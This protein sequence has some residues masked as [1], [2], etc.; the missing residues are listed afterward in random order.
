VSAADIAAA[1][2]QG[3]DALCDVLRRRAAPGVSHEDPPLEAALLDAARSVLEKA[4]SA[5][6]GSQRVGDRAR[7]LVGLA[8]IY[9]STTSIQTL[10]AAERALVE[11]LQAVPIEVVGVLALDAYRLLLDVLV[12][13]V[14]A[15]SAEQRETFIERALGFA[16]A[17]GYVA[18]RMADDLGRARALAH[19]AALL[20]ERFRGDRDDNLMNAVDTGE[21]ALA[22]LPAG[23][24]ELEL[25][26]PL[27]LLVMG[28]ASVKIAADREAWL[29][30]GIEYYTKGRASVD[31]TRHPGLAR[32]LEGNAAVYREQSEEERRQLPPKE[33]YARSSAR[34]RESAAA[35]DVE[36][37][38]ATASDTIAWAHALA[39]QPNQYV[40]HAHVTLGQLYLSLERWREAREQLDQGLVV[41]TSLFA[42]GS[43]GHGYVRSALALREQAVAK[44]GGSATSCRG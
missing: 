4:V 7:A 12:K 41:L 1:L 27:L 44:E 16:R 40:G 39:D 43:H 29:R 33:M 23:T 5:A 19:E 32:V 17:G 31:V 9:A 13:V 15:V 24:L 3:P 25:R 6:Q 36:A 37:A 10:Q 22:L 30:R 2:V 34:V 35:G 38:L 11:A 14:D 28:N 42:P 20:S 18:T 8:H 21:R 26:W